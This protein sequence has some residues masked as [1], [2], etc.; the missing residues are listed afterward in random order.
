LSKLFAVPV[1]PPEQ[2][3]KDQVLLPVAVNDLMKSTVL[4]PERYVLQPTLEEVQAF[5]A[6]EFAFDI[7]V[8][9]YRT[10]GEHAPVE[11]VGL[12]DRLYHAI[13][14][15]VRGA[16]LGELKRIFGN[17]T[18]LIGQNCIQYDIPKLFGQL[19]MEWW[20]GKWDGQVWDIM[21]MQHLLFPDFPHDLAF[22]GS[23]FTNKPAWKH[24]SGENMELYNARDVDVTF[25]AW[26]QLKA[27]LKQQKLLDLY[28]LVQVPLAK[29]CRLITDTGVTLNPNRLGEIRE[30][31]LGEVAENE[32]K[33]PLHMRTQQV[34]VKRRSP[35]PEGTVSEK[36]GKPLKFVMVDAVDTVVPWRSPD[37]KKEFLYGPA[38]K[39]GLG[40]PEQKKVDTEKV[41]T[42]KRALGRLFRITQNP[43]ISAL[44]K[45][46]GLDE[47]LSS[48]VAEKAAKITKQRASFNPHGTNSGR[49]SSSGPNM[50]NQ[51]LSTRYIYVPSHDGWEWGSFDFS[52]IENRLAAYYANDQKRL[53]RY[54]DPKYSDYKMLASRAFNIPYDEV[55]KD[56]DREAPYGM[57]KAVVLGF[58]YGLGAIKCA[59][60]ND[61][62]L[63]EVKKLF[64]QWALEIPDTVRWREETAKKAD[65]DGFLTNNFGRKRWFWGSSVY[66]ESLSFLPQS[67]A[68]DIIIR[69]MIALMY[70]R[71]G[72]PLEKV[73]KVV[74]VAKPLPWPARL[75]IQVHDS[76]EFEYPQELREEV[77]NTVR[78]VFQQPWPELG[79]FN[80]PVSVEVGPSWGEV[81]PYV[82]QTMQEEVRAG[83]QGEPLPEVLHK[84]GAPEISSPTTETEVTL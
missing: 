31:L 75:V 60:M 82:L 4:P 15:P 44:K 78:A 65:K 40:L 71:I 33:L 45:L 39:G 79:G 6:T 68:A 25:Q 62:D 14:V 58:N 18:S 48:F 36:T 8:P 52:N 61:M 7:E 1:L 2:L 57:A 64:A 24:L 38:E 54:L 74:R 67:T 34:P 56:N 63:R 72:W 19:G 37:K 76:L 83:R 29:I 10:M 3:M 49:L 51:P 77:V 11:M 47:L 41:T 22:I 35:A 9:K 46:N 80:I 55:E 27:M 23:Q 28:E 5:T 32:R 66:T 30:Q 84:D 20:E 73:L 42:D 50:Q 16:Y 70:E 26:T 12:S 59:R 21:L 13:V 53:A 69:C 43:A 17:A 81:R